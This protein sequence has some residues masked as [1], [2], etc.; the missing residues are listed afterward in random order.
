[1]SD[2]DMMDVDNDGDLDVVFNAFKNIQEDELI[3][4][5]SGKLNDNI[6][7]NNIATVNFDKLI[8][9]N[10]NGKF[11]SKNLGLQRK[12]NYAG[13]LVWI[14]PFKVNNKFKFVCLFRKGDYN[15]PS[16]YS[17]SIVEVYPKF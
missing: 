4:G 6:S 15:I 7:F 11:I 1:M 8:Y 17:T 2:F 9:F 13:A 10:E 14:K 12:F 5:F 16:S 3:Y